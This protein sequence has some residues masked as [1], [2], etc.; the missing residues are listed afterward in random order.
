ME[1]FLG[2]VLVLFDE[3]LLVCNLS[4]KIVLVIGVGGSIG[5]ELC[6]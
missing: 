1:D 5:S 3:E 4:Y 6:C 2:C